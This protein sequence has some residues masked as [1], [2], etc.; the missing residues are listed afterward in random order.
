MNN[1]IMTLAMILKYVLEAFRLVLEE[2][3][4]MLKFVYKYYSELFYT[5]SKKMNHNTKLNFKIQLYPIKH[6]SG[7]FEYINGLLSFFLF[8]LPKSFKS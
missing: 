1:K 7:Y 8:N 3:I 4:I 6:I 2:D 5:L